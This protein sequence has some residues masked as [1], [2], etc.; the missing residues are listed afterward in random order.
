MNSQSASGTCNP[1]IAKNQKYFQ[2]S[3][4]S[5]QHSLF[6]L[7]GSLA[8]RTAQQVSFGINPFMCHPFRS[9]LVIFYLVL[10]LNTQIHGQAWA[11]ESRLL[12]SWFM[13]QQVRVNDFFTFS[14]QLRAVYSKWFLLSRTKAPTLANDHRSHIC[15]LFTAPS[16]YPLQKK[17]ECLWISSKLCA[18]F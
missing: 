8:L 12:H 17:L 9:K 10:L 5:L 15:T 14:N 7:Y 18:Q 6:C 11:T 3:K 16:V 1:L 13:I 2:I 4:N